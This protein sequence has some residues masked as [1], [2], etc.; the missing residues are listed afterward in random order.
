MT[1]Q[2]EEAILD[3]LTAKEKLRKKNAKQTNSSYT[4]A[5][6]AADIMQ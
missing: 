1:A 4:P 2:E 6:V 5:P 3:A